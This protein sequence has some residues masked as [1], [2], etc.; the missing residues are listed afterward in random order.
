MQGSGGKNVFMVDKKSKSNLNQIIEAI[1]TDGFIIAQEYLPRAKDGDTRF[2]LMNGVPL[3][4][5]GVCAAM[6]RVNK[7]GDIRNNIHAGGN[8]G[9]CQ[10]KKITE[11]RAL[12]I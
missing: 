1:S 6:K 5:D 11:R 10:H 12:E 3:Q 9:P 8:T 4:K 2:F 7:E